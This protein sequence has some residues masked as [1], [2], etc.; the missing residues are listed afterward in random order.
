MCLC[1]DIWEEGA[2]NGE[3]YGGYYWDEF[4]KE[5]LHLAVFVSTVGTDE[6][7]NQYYYVNNVIDCPVNGDTPY[8]YR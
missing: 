3:L 7:G 4:N 1:D 6:K 2:L 8:E 5:N